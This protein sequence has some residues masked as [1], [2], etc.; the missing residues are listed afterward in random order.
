MIRDKLQQDM[1]FALKS[2]DKTTLS[3]LRLVLSQINYLQI[4]KQGELTDDDVMGLLRKEIK[5][6]KR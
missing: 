2:A 1:T 3:V 5:K 6:E 4:D